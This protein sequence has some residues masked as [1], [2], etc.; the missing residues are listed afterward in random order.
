MQ[1]SHPLLDFSLIPHGGL[2]TVDGHYYIKQAHVDNV[3]INVSTGF[4]RNFPDSEIAC[5][6]FRYLPKA[7]IVIE[8]F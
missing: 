1:I 8:D 4:V 3:G 7:K 2:F 6:S 5:R